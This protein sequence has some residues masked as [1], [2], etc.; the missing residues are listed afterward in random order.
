MSVFFKVT[1]CEDYVSMIAKYET[2]FTQVRLVNNIKVL[3]DKA[4]CKSSYHCTMMRRSDNSSLLR[5]FESKAL[6][7]GMLQKVLTAGSLGR[8]LVKTSLEEN[9]GRIFSRVRPSYEHVVSDL[10]RSMNISLWV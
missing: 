5:V 3:N 4:F 7:V 6:E 10:E 1:F 9:R 8:V 2:H